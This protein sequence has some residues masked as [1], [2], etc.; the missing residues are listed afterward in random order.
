LDQYT[1]GAELLKKYE[2][3][4]SKATWDVN[5]WRIGYGSDTI[6]LNNGTNRK[7]VQ[8]DQ[9]NEANATKD[10]I[11]RV[12]QF[13]KKIINQ[14]GEEFWTPLNYKVKAPLISLAYNY[15]SITKQAI[16][17]A[18]K[19][20]NSETIANAVVNSTYNDNKSQSAQVRQALRNRRKKE[21]DIIRQAPNAK[22]AGFNKK[23]L[24]IPL[25]LFVATY[26][27][28]KK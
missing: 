27:N 1:F 12:K 11:R 18:I 6:T 9:T 13:E 14:I 3:Y 17:D 26:L 28:K 2:G 20:G 21:S 10:L 25:I 4:N 23:L 8:G 19:T 7:V 5:A 15:G 24:L 16:R 22:K